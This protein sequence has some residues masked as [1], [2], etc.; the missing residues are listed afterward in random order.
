MT[1]DLGG[2]MQSVILP[3][4]DRF[5]QP[6]VQRLDQM[7]THS[8][9]D[10]ASLHTKFDRFM[11]LGQDVAAAKVSGDLNAAAIKGLE[12][13]HHSNVIE[14]AEMRGRNRVV[15]YVLIFIGGPV[16]A[17]LVLAGLTTLLHW[18]P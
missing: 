16:V 14:M 13:A 5:V 8:R 3:L 10:I 7:E 4:I 11:G 12:D 1:A 6:L 15:S 18:H 9:E 2:E 17:G